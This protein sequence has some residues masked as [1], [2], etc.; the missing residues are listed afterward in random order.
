MNEKN[1]DKK[2][3]SDSSEE[4]DEV[5]LDFDDEKTEEVR[6]TIPSTEEELA[7][8]EDKYLRLQAEFDNYRK[9]MSAR[10]DEATRFAS[11]SIILKSLEVV[12][13]LQRALEADFGVDPESAKSGIQA[14]HKQMEKIL[15]NEHVRPIDSVGKEFDP[16]YQNAIQTVTD[17]SLPDKIVIQEFQ[18]GY[19]IREKVLRPAMVSVNRHAIPLPADNGTDHITD[20]DELI[21]ELRN[22]NETAEKNGDDKCQE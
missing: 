3:G 17:E 2:M 12:D 22:D 7:I 9:R 5:T 4:S 20:S 14:I 18:K 15:M 10:Y 13:N 11:E 21:E 8:L 1:D 19:M 16:Y 6:K